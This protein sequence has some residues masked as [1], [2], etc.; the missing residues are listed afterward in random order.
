M[1]LLFNHFLQMNY[2]R[3]FQKILHNISFIFFKPCRPTVLHSE[4]NLF[5][6]MKFRVTF[7]YLVAYLSSYHEKAIKALYE[8]A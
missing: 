6:I 7:F 3:E 2:L 8:L 4:N 5:L 1:F